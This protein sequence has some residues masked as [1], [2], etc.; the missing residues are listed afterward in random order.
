MEEWAWLGAVQSCRPWTG[1][2]L[3]AAISW[4][5]SGK[6]ATVPTVF[7]WIRIQPLGN[8]KQNPDPRE[9]SKTIKTSCNKKYQYI[10]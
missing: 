9:D 2:Y 10:Y 4:T 7:D 3:P 8:E 1:E 6:G 5:P